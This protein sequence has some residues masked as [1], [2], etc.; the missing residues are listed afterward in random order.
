MLCHQKGSKMSLIG[1]ASNGGIIGFVVFNVLI[2]FM[3]RL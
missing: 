3:N 1:T 2:T